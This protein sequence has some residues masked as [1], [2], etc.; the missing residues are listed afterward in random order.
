MTRT[1]E[2]R[3]NFAVK[4]MRNHV[5]MFIYLY[6]WLIKFPQIC[7]IVLYRINKLNLIILK[8]QIYFSDV[9]YAI[10]WEVCVNVL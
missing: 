1:N 3:V 9:G 8:I 4:I 2:C 5:I 10:F 7:G 6:K